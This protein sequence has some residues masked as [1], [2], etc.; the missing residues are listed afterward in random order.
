[1][2]LF[3]KNRRSAFCKSILKTINEEKPV[4][5]VHVLS[6]LN[7]FYEDNATLLSLYSHGYCM[8]AL[9]I[10]LSRNNDYNTVG[11]IL[12]EINERFGKYISKN[13]IQPSISGKDANDLVNDVL[14]KNNMK[15]SFVKH[16]LSSDSSDNLEVITSSYLQDIGISH[17]DIEYINEK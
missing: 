8:G 10:E 7:I 12:R 2:G 16:I 14:A 4:N 17:F 11:E 6:S 3:K 15:S 9:E 1:M 13:L 5:M